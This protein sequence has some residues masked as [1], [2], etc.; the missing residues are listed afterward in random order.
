[1]TLFFRG[2]NCTQEAEQSDPSDHIRVA[3]R[4]PWGAVSRPVVRQVVQPQ[5]LKPLFGARR[6]YVPAW[7]ASAAHDGN[8][9]DNFEFLMYSSI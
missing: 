3:A 7:Q 4:P 6:L 1:M 2:I 5:H 8:D 9:D